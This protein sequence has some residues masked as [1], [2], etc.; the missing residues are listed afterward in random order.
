M[1]AEARE[2]KKSVRAAHRG[3]VTRIIG[4]V[5]GAIEAS[6]EAQLKQHIRSLKEKSAK[7]SNL[8]DE[9]LE[10]TE[11][12]QLDAE[13]EH[14][15]VIQERI[16]LS[17]IKMEETLARLTNVTSGRESGSRGGGTRPAER[18]T[19]TVEHDHGTHEE[20]ARTREHET[21]G[22]D[23]DSGRTDATDDDSGTPDSTPV[24]AVARVKLP[25]LTI[26]KFNGDLT[27]WVTFWDS[28]NSSIHANPAL[29]SI[30]KFNYLISLL[31]STASEAIAG[32][33]LTSANYDEAISTLRKRFGNSQLI[34][35]RHMENLMNTTA[36]TSHHD[37]KGL[38]RLLDS[39]EAQV[40]GLRGLGVL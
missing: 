25:K 15:D 17:I 3:S 2:R 28:F 36:V 16:S 11:V 31:E 12:D 38:R 8:D 6:D 5:Q 14:A 9:I 7:L 20:P 10:L 23:H 4:Q 39:V 22:T 30:D 32:L 18:H 19:A 34:I 29:S 24:T 21:P 26:K 27:R 37:I 33:A 40:R 1:D 13:V 35:N